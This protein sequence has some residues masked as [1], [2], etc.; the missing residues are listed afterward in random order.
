VGEE[1]RL[2]V[3]PRHSIT[4]NHLRYRREHYQAKA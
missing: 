4:E 2:E 1:G 3:D